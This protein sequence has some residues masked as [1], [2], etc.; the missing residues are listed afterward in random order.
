MRF[1]LTFFITIIIIIKEANGDYEGLT[2]HRNKKVWGGDTW[3]EPLKD[4]RRCEF[5]LYR[6]E[7]IPDYRKCDQSQQ[8]CLRN[9]PCFH[10]AKV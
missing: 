6:W 3:T 10:G 4:M 5:I 1:L 9:R 2:P 8:A 7:D